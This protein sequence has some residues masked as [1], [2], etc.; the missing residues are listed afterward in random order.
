MSNIYLLFISFFHFFYIIKFSLYI[1][2]I[3]LNL[4]ILRLITAN[5]TFWYQY[6][7]SMLEL[8]QTNYFDHDT[9]STVYRLTACCRPLSH[10]KLSQC[11]GEGRAEISWLSLQVFAE[12]FSW[13]VCH[14]DGGGEMVE[15]IQLISV[16]KHSQVVG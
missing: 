7:I 14:Y 6:L 15:M 2:W 12:T 5:L 11:P 16:V 4:R 9:P 8:K 13:R 10:L 3:K 1:L